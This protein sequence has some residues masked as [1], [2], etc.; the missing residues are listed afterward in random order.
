[1]PPAQGCT[2]VTKP[3]MVLPIRNTQDTPEPV[4]S[5]EKRTSAMQ[6]LAMVA[7]LGGGMPELRARVRHEKVIPCHACGKYT[8]TTTGECRACGSYVCGGCHL[9][10]LD[11]AT[12]TCPGN[13]TPV[14][15]HLSKHQL[16]LQKRQQKNE[17]M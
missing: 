10:H 6:V 8:K 16:R 4:L 1:V 17:V 9:M 3:K 5:S 7:S 13:G 11:S 2:Q 15:K 12:Q 14:P